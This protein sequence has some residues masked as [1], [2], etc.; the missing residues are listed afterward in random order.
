MVLTGNFNEPRCAMQ[1]GQVVTWGQDPNGERWALRDEWTCDGVTGSGERWDATVRWFF[2]SPEENGMRNAFWDVAGHGAVKA[3]HLA[4]GAKRWFDHEFVSDDFRVDDCRYLHAFREEG[5][6]DLSALMAML[7]F[8][9]RKEG[10]VLR[11]TK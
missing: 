1:G 8:D 4:R 11:G 2:Q 9:P 10:V 6:S 7:S 5:F 3:S